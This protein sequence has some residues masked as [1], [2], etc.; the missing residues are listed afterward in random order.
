MRYNQQIPSFE[1]DLWQLDKKLIAKKETLDSGG[2]LSKKPSHGNY[3]RFIAS[4][5]SIK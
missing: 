2:H 3:Q 4:Q 5:I 1:N